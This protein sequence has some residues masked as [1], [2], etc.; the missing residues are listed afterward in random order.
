MKI[1]RN[2]VE[3][4]GELFL[5]EFIFELKTNQSSCKVKSWYAGSEFAKGTSGAI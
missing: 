3:R 2:I 4:F 5:F 1:K